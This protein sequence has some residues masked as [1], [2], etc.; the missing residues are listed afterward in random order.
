MF[1]W[2]DNIKFPQILHDEVIKRVHQNYNNKEKYFSSFHESG[3]KFADILVPYYGNLVK[4]MMKD[5]GLYS[6]TKY[7]YNVWVQ[8]YNSKTTSHAPH[9]HFSG[10]EIISFTHIIDASPKKCFYFLNDNGDKIYPEHQESGDIFAWPPWRRHG[11]DKV[12]EPNVN[13]LII[14]GNISIKSYREL[15]PPHSVDKHMQ[16]LKDIGLSFHRTRTLN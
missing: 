8:M 2:S 3:Q 11:V 16:W 1:I 13:R 4:E 10:K 6:R 7:L 12:Q 15:P 5:L 9:E 14:A